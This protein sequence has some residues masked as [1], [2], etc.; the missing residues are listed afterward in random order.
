MDPVKITGVVEWPVPTS[1]KEVQSFMG[2]TNFYCWFI[3]N[4][5]H[6]ARMLFDLTKKDVRFVWGNREQDAFDRLKELVTSALVLALPDSSGVAT[7]AVLSQL[8]LDVTYS[9]LYMF[10]LIY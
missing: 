3:S 4:F 6:H 8:S 5:S 10:V 7:G 1:K 2:F 9:A